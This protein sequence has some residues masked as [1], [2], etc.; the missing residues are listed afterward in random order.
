VKVRYISLVSGLLTT[1]G[2]FILLEEMGLSGSG[3]LYSLLRVANAWSWL[4]TFLGFASRHLNF[5][6]RILRYANEAVLPFYILH[7]TVTVVVGY[8]IA[9]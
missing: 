9:A 3:S 2:G 5:S 7:Q 4:S 6:N 1:I 8:F